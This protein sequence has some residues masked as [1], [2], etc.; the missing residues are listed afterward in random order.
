MSDD[1]V[2]RVLGSEHASTAAFRVVLDDDDFLQL[3]DL[4]VVRTHVPKAG[5]VVS[6]IL[7][8]LEKQTRELMTQLRNAPIAQSLQAPVEARE[9]T[10]L[11]AANEL[12][13]KTL[14]A[15]RLEAVVTVDEMVDNVTFQWFKD[16][17]PF[18]E[19]WESDAPWGAGCEPGGMKFAWESTLK[20]PE[21]GR[22][23][24]GRYTVTATVRFAP[25]RPAVLSHTGTIT[26]EVVH[27]PKITAE[28]VAPLL[29]QP[30]RL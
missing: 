22:E 10:D 3:D 26:L 11:P 18:P 23:D 15:M 20:F 9:R 21:I 1:G 5:E 27:G 14:E 24:A 30:V 4:V 2:G 6:G 25:P 17:R 19:P 12:M 7:E 8:E 28:P 13:Q 16:G 29:N